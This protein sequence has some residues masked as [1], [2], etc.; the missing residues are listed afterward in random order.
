MIYLNNIAFLN[1]APGIFGGRLPQIAHINNLQ[2]SKVEQS[3][4]LLEEATVIFG[5]ETDDNNIETL[6]IKNASK[7]EY[8][9]KVY[10]GLKYVPLCTI[11]I[12]HSNYGISKVEETYRRD[13][14]SGYRK[15]LNKLNISLSSNLIYYNIR[16]IDTNRVTDSWIE[17]MTS[18]TTLKFRQYIRYYNVPY[19]RIGLF[20]LPLTGD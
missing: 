16:P 12:L 15:L 19:I 5:I 8:N 7:I 11:D 10:Y 3:V 13:R 17:S 6:N 14:I 2:I 18:S 4:G 9:Y 20:V 1:Y